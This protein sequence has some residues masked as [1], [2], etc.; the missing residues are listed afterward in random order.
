[1]PDH[2]QVYNRQAKLYD[3]MTSCQP[4]LLPAILAIRSLE[5]LDIVDTGA[6]TG[7][8]A[9][10]LAPYARTLSVFDRSEAM[11]SLTQ[12]K[13]SA[14]LPADR[15][16]CGTADHRSLPVADSSADLVTAGWS[17]CYLASSN[18]ADWQISLEQTIAEFRRIL[19]PG[20]TIIIF[21][22]MGT[23]TNGPQP[24]DFLTR[25]YRQ[26]EE[27]YGFS[28]SLLQLDYTFSSVEEAAELTNFFFGE[29]LSRQALANGTSVVPE[30]AGMWTL[31]V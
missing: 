18:H 19:R 30:W 29:A 17:I 8:L 27:T 26:L 6:G 28:F 5:G 23:G 25:Y 12:E 4:S 10:V 22:T 20:G 24:P 31:T 15:F 7:R 21:E 11:L 9:S 14:L 2:D 1:M 3:R 16:H 13:V